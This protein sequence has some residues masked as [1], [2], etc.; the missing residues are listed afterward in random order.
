MPK[1]L[2]EK[3]FKPLVLILS[4]TAIA[5]AMGAYLGYRLSRGTG[6]VG[7]TGLPTGAE[8]VPQD[9]VMTLTVS[10]D[11]QQW[12][13]VR[14]LGT[15]ESR[16]RFDT[17]LVQWR[18]RFLTA[19][20]LDYEDDIQPWVGEA[21]TLVML[22]RPTPG[23]EEPAPEPEEPTE[24]PAAESE[25]AEEGFALPED[26]VD[27]RDPL[28]MA[29]V[30]PIAN[31]LQAQDRLTT[32]LDESG[33]T[34]QTRDYEGFTI[35]EIDGEGD[36][37][38]VATVLDQ[39]YVVVGTQASSVEQVIDA[40]R[41]DALT[42]VAG[43]RQAIAEVSTDQ[44]FLQVYLNAPAT[45]LEFESRSAEPVPLVG[46]TPLQRNQ[47][48]AASLSVDTEQIKVQGI[49]WLPEDS[50]LR[51][52]VSNNGGELTGL[53]PADTRLLV[54]TT[55][56][57]RIWD[58]Y[59]QDSGVN[60]QN[61]LN[62]NTFEAG[63]STLTGLDWNQD[64]LAWMDGEVG[65]AMV[66]PTVATSEP[67]LGFVLMAQT[68]NRTAAEQALTSLDAV[69]RDRYQFQVNQ[70]Q[71]DE[72]PF[73][74]WQSPFGSLSMTHGWITDNVVF[75]AIGSETT[76]LL[77]PQPEVALNET[78]AFSVTQA[79]DFNAYNGRFFLDLDSLQGRATPLPTPQLPDR[80]GAIAD[81]IRQI[82]VTSAVRSD[83]STRFEILLQVVQEG[84]VEP[85]PPPGAVPLPE[86]EPDG[87]AFIE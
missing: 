23:T 35:Q 77:L 32:A 40:Y 69:M 1:A 53:L 27:P 58:S 30:L 49:N 52:P 57:Q 29:L 39:Q 45:R 15:A 9:A 66:Q 68:S 21:V 31:P 50:E 16:S 20:G 3:K 72:I 25:S 76:S 83:R 43:Y 41:G 28:P 10:T 42:G 8:V 67:Q 14:S 18:D 71:V 74:V 36:Q 64:L 37:D 55:D 44:P 81:A 54:T 84:D 56:L 17:Q 2:P 4:G 11:E 38:Y 79:E 62:P 51:Y 34:V 12:R 73:T 33:S 86:A 70:G 75:L 80:A 46:M 85:L 19:N 47:G 22:P 87:E 26:F 24:D 48:M 7:G 5:V 82:G 61:P 60:P 63:I 78:E 59:R 65:V 13:Q 6:F